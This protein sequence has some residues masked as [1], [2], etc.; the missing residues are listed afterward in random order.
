KEMLL[1]FANGIQRLDSGVYITGP[2]L[3]YFGQWDAMSRPKRLG[4]SFFDY[5]DTSVQTDKY[6]FVSCIQFLVA[7]NFGYSG[8]EQR[9]NVIGDGLDQPNYALAMLH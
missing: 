4:W 6:G 3:S 1:N 9:F 7:S 5:E 8:F 2:L